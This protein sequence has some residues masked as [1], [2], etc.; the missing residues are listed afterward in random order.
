MRNILN[1]R[2]LTRIGQARGWAAVAFG[3]AGALFND[4]NTAASF[5]G[6]SAKIEIPYAAALNPANFSVEVW[7]K[8]AGGQGNIPGGRVRSRRRR[9]I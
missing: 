8:V 1:P 2:K 3:T 4:A 6:V 9:W 7:A 5:D